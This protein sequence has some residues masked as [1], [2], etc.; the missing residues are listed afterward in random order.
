[1]ND[2]NKAC[3]C[4]SGGGSLR[5]PCPTHPILANNEQGG[6]VRLEDAPTI[7][8]RARELLLSHYRAAGFEDG[9]PLAASDANAVAIK[10]IAAALSAQHPPMQPVILDKSGH[11]RFRENTLVRAL[12]DHGTRTGFG[13]NQLAVQDHSAEDRMQLAQLT[14][15]SVYGYGMLS[16]VTDASYEEAARRGA[17]L[18]APPTQAVDM[19]AAQAVAVYDAVTRRNF[20]RD[21][22]TDEDKA[23]TVTAALTD[24]QAVGK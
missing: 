10:A 19:T 3:T 14:G 13:L 21:V 8:K 24:S 16:Y 22:K 18:A 20:T 4:P 11:E 9:A 6:R 1:M 23:R 7:E 12:L 17:M 15:Y 2:A 5:H